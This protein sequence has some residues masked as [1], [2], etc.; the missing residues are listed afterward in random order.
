MKN[1][2]RMTMAVLAAIVLLLAGCS[3][4]LQPSSP[5]TDATGSAAS[6]TIKMTIFIPD[7][8][9]ARRG[10]AAA[11]VIDPKTYQAALYIEWESETWQSI[12]DWHDPIGP[13]LVTDLTPVDGSPYYSTGKVVFSGIPAG[14]YGAGR[15]H[16]LFTDSSGGILTAGKTSSDVTVVEDQTVQGVPVYCFPVNFIPMSIGGTAIGKDLTAGRVEYLSFPVAA[17][18]SYRIAVTRTSGEGSPDLYVFNPDG[19]PNTSALYQAGLDTQRDVSFNTDGTAWAGLYGY[20]GA[21]LASFQIFLTPAANNPPVAVIQASSLNVDAGNF[22]SFYGNQSQDNDAGDWV[23]TYLWDFGDGTTSDEN[24]TVHTY[25]KAGE[26][27]VSLTVADSHDL[28]SSPKY[29][30]VTVNSIQINGILMLPYSATGRAW[31]VTVDDGNGFVKTTSGTCDETISVPYAVGGLDASLYYISANVDVDGVEGIGHGDFS[32]TADGGNQVPIY[33][34]GNS[35][36]IQLN[37]INNAPTAT[38]YV[39]TWDPSARLVQLCVNGYDEDGD[40]LTVNWQID[41]APPGSTAVFSDSTVS[42]PTFG[43]V[44]GG[45]YYISVWLSDGWAARQFSYNFNVT[46]GGVTFGVY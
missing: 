44:I 30:A 24:Y 27:A 41:Q 26:Y 8:A 34:A 23:K 3:F 28:S 20:N 2:I 31:K 15:L 14:T 40:P 43:P 21:C 17:G 5:K 29:A 19:T 12:G 32:G 38:I 6:S 22:I 25:M 1:T 4:P 39:S 35:V 46:S 37:V 16:L 11:K 7:Y 9:K 10:T 45:V 42:M 13:N 36:A 33:G 18:T